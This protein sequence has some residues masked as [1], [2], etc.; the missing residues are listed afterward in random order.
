[1]APQC[2]T[3]EALRMFE[4]AY[5]IEPEHFIAEVKRCRARQLEAA[6]LDYL[7]ARRKLEAA[8]ELTEQEQIPADYI[9]DCEVIESADNCEKIDVLSAYRKSQE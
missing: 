4:T 7:E 1:M 3:R 8:K 9:H 6:T 5:H 2:I